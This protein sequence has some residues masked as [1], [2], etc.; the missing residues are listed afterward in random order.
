M[1]SQLFQPFRLGQWIRYAFVG[2]LAG[3]MGTAGGCNLQL[4]FNLP[5][6]ESQRFQLPVPIAERGLVFLAALGLLIVLF[7]IA[8][9]LL[10]YVSSRMRFV[11]FDSI[12]TG[13][14]QIGRFWNARG[15]PAWRYFVWQILF[16]LCSI[17]AFALVVGIPLAA[18][19]ATGVFR[20]PRSHLVALIAGGILV[21][22]TVLLL[23]L[24]TAV[25]HVLTKDF[26]VPQMAF[27]GISAVEGWRR[28]WPI[29]KS[30]SGGFAGY[31]G[32][33]V[34]LAVGTTILITIAIFIVV[35]VLLIPIGVIG[36]LLYLWSRS[37]ALAWNPL[38]LTLA[39]LA[40]IA[41]LSVFLILC[42]LISVPAIVF[43][44]SYSIH[45]FADRYAPL[46]NVLFPA[47]PPDE[48]IL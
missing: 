6:Q 16:L 11:L 13:E 21:G 7:V 39:V 34:V 2:L 44:P 40:G 18:A 48:T 1:K 5:S 20:D 24:S 26:V 31:V 27:E 29:M 45:Y 17:A 43:F 22:L 30:E 46:R 15:E 37:V 19:A 12:V 8:G 42:A 10:L 33:K 9:I 28:V 14:C 25:I 23:V 36:A 3:E 35:F 38:T 4:P 47:A 41:I 32:L